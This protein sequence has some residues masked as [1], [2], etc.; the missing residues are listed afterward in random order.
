[1]VA[2]VAHFNRFLS[3]SKGLIRLGTVY[4]CEGRGV[5]VREDKVGAKYYPNHS[6][7]AKVRL[8]VGC[9]NFRPN[10]KKILKRL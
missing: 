9:P 10:D 8:G 4:V 3:V 1:M 2:I 7:E 5:G 6:R